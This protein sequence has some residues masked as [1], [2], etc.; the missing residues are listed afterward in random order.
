MKIIILLIGIILLQ[1]CE[2]KKLNEKEILEIIHSHE[3]YKDLELKTDFSYNDDYID[4]IKSFKEII[5]KEN[6]KP[7]YEADFN[8][9][10][11][12]DYLVNLSYPKS[13]NE[14]NIVKIYIEEDHK[15]T[16]L[17][18]S[19]KRGYQILNPGKQKVY[20][21]ISAKILHYKNQYL[22]KLLN[23]KKHTNHQDDMFQYDTLMIK[24]NQIT[25]FTPTN[26]RHIEKI[27]CHQNGGY[28]P[29][30]IYSLTIKKDS[31]ILHSSYYKDLK[32]KYFV[33][34]NSSFKT[35]SKYLNEINFSNLKSRYS[36]SCQD[37]SS[38]EIE[39]TFDNGKTT[40]IYD[41]GEKGTLGLLKFYEKIDTIIN[42]E[43][44]KKI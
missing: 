8:N 13:K 1:S 22:I 43:K 9:D 14:G 11:K 7:I 32:G 36:I 23:F 21:I 20:D 35:L 26:N 41:Y 6:F 42:K 12:K 24:K 5:N 10:S 15:N 38:I 28:A 3:E 2:K 34:D 31:T 29:G 39:I 27:V 19:S 16:L 40:K 18:L 33:I 25:E 44:W 30:R 4:S 37:C 17:L